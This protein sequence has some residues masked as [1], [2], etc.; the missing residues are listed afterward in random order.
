VASNATTVLVP[1][2]EAQPVMAAWEVQRVLGI[3]RSSLYEALRAG[4]VPGIRIGARWFVPTAAVRRML[5]MDE[6]GHA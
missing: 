2:P 1:D 5:Q 6:A 4:Q 3:S